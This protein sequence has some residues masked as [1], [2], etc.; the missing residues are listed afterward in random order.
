MPGTDLYEI[1][2]IIN[3]ISSVMEK[4]ERDMIVAPTKEKE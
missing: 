1:E 2:D 4:R 3:E